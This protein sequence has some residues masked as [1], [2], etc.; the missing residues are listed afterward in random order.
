MKYVYMFTDC[1]TPRDVAVFDSLDEAKQHGYKNYLVGMT[2]E[3]IA[4]IG[5]E[6][7]WKEIEPNLYEHEDACPAYIVGVP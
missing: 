5:S 4:S 7:E 1:G 2:T 6:L 3:E